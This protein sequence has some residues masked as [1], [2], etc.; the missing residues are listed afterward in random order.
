MER[1]GYA[2]ISTFHFGNP[3]FTNTEPFLQRWRG[4]IPYVALQDAHGGE[5]WWFAD[6]TTGFRTV[7]L[8]SEPGW[9]AWLDALKQNRVAA[10]RHDAVSRSQTWIHAGPSEVVDFIRARELTWRWWDNPEIARPMVSVVAVKPEDEFEIAR[11]N[12]GVTLRVRCAWENTAQGLL[13]TPLA[14]LLKVTVDDSEV[15]PELVSTKAPRG[16]QLSDQYHHV[17]LTQLAPGKH[18][19][20]AFIRVLATQMETSRSL[21]FE[22]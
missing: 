20:S 3:D 6:M 7:F 1:G 19:A 4:Q 22:V 2:A 12:S 8:A 18:R 21:E 17:H 13:K 9:D 11:P 16:V 10:I 14:E 15:S 5:P